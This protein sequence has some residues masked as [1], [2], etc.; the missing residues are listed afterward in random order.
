MN[1]LEDLSGGRRV[2][3]GGGSE[4]A[5]VPTAAGAPDLEAG[6]RDLRDRLGVP[7]LEGA[8]DAKVADD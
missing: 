8:P 3:P 4:S 6:D 7:A 1:L 5:V 2:A